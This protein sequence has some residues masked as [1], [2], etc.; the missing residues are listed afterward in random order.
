M[1][2]TYR[3]ADNGAIMLWYEFYNTGH[4]TADAPTWFPLCTFVSFVVNACKK[5]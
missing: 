3:S 5:L 4:S 1:V 2:T